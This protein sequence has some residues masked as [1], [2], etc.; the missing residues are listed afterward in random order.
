MLISSNP[1]D[2]ALLSRLIFS[3]FELFTWFNYPWCFW[4]Y[5]NKWLSLFCACLCIAIM[6]MIDWRVS[7]ITLACVFLF[8]FIVLYRKPGWNNLMDPNKIAL[9]LKSRLFLCY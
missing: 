7:L 8:Y 4:Q 9:S 3:T 2:G 6:F 5:Y 1:L